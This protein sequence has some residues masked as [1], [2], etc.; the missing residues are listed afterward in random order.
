MKGYHD[1]PKPLGYIIYRAWFDDEE[2]GIMTDPLIFDFFLSLF[3]VLWG[4][5]LC[6]TVLTLCL[7]F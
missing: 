4:E 6:W 3:I 2:H 7:Q 1:N 5:A